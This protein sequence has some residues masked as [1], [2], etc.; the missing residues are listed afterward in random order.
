[1]CG[2]VDD[3]MGRTCGTHGRDDKCIQYFGC[4]NLKEIDHSEDLGACE[5]I[6]L[7]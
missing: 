2:Y 4:K 6:I 5:R 3:K 7:E 1:M